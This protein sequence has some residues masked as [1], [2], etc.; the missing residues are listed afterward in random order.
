MTDR[1]LQLAESGFAT[2]DQAG[3]FLAISGRRVRQLREAGVISSAI[4]GGRIVF[5][6]VSLKQ[7]A[8]SRIQIGSVA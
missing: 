2:A 7:Y 8:A 5:P 1:K 3:E 6:W 4:I